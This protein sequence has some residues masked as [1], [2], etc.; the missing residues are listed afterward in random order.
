MSDSAG[1]LRFYIGIQTELTAQTSP[2]MLDR[3][4]RLHSHMPK[5]MRTADAPAMRGESVG[6]MR[7]SDRDVDR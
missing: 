4:Q 6:L 2:R 5:V 7:L 3:L 1:V